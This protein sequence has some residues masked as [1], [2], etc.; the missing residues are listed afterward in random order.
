MIPGLSL[1]PFDGHLGGPQ[2]SVGIN[3]EIG[4][5]CTCLSV[6]TDIVLEVELGLKVPMHL[7]F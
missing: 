1:P 4:S 5:F 6:S 2:A 7:L 3:L